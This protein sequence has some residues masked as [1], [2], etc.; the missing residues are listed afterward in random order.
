MVVML[1]IN[2]TEQ[3]FLLKLARQS[4]EYYLDH[5][6]QLKVDDSDLP[7]KDLIEK[8]ACFVTLKIDGQLRGCVGHLEPIRPIYKDVIENAVAAAFYDTRF[9]PLGKE[10]VGQIKIEI[11]IL[12]LPKKLSHQKSQ[13]LIEMLQR[14]KPGVIIQKGTHKATF[15]PQVWEEL[16]SPEDFLS[17]LCLK[18]GLDSKDWQR[19]QIDISTY[20]VE[21]FKE[22]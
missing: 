7:F 6:F 10:E 2:K 12:S 1:S 5:N 8:R 9:W 19:K 21:A 3:N 18:A 4:I 20:S 16:S 22:L 14:T 17:N 11:S 13:D 15:L